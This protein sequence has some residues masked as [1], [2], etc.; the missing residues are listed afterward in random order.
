VSERTV[1]VGVST[2]P[3]ERQRL[4]HALAAA[5]H[6]E[7]KTWFVDSSGAATADGG[8]VL[9][10]VPPGISPV[11]TVVPLQWLAYWTAVQDGLNPDIMGLDDP[12]VLA[13]RSSFGI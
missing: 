13:A 11:V 6:L 9:P 5:R 2:T 1:V 3:L 8:L 7:A 12:K 4:D 10:P